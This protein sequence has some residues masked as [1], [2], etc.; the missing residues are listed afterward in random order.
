MTVAWKRWDYEP[1]HGPGFEQGV[2]CG[3][4]GLPLEGPL[5]SA[6]YPTWVHLA[7]DGE[8]LYPEPKHPV[9]VV[10]ASWYS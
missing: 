2:T 5:G 7:G 8:Y 1:R 10:R 4:C 9:Q 6:E 3:V